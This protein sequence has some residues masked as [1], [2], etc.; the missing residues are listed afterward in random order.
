[1][2]DSGLVIGG[3]RSPSTQKSEDTRRISIIDPLRGLAALAVAW[4]HFT[5]GTPSFLHDGWLKSSGTYGWMGVDVFFVISGFVLP[6]SM[7]RGNYRI[8]DH[9]LTFFKKRLTRLEPPYLAS[10]VLALV[11]LVLSSRMPGFAGGPIRVR[12]TDIL[13][14]IAYLN[15]FTGGT[16]LNP[17]YWTLAVEFQFYLIISLAFPFA[18]SPN[19]STRIAAVVVLSLLA[20]TNDNT[21]WVIRYLPL[22]ALGI[23][24]FQYFARL[25]SR[26]VYLSLLACIA[27]VSCVGLGWLVSV[28]SVGTALSIS[29]VSW[30]PPAR[31]I[32][33]GAISYS[34]Y[35]LHVPI[36]GRVVNLGSRLP[37]SAMLRA[38]TL[39]L[40]AVV[41]VF[42][43]YLFAEWIE[44]PAQ[45]W[46][47]SIKYIVRRRKDEA[48]HRTSS[49]PALPEGEP[50][51]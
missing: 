27:G 4:F 26:Q 8:R 31:L 47:A 38:A 43:A 41:S 11:L 15:A 46:S 18:V 40:A 36:G 39:I 44:Q 3:L 21:A 20:V 17:V 33:L 30:Q 1:M 42:A 28:V 7:Y 50:S 35:L 45:R 23:L 24:T 5:H 10:V 48:A 22:F 19:R 16:W 29:F 34:L 12:L 13:Q 9:W 6:Y 37:Y 25:I 14:H 51:L 2:S 32:K 49:I